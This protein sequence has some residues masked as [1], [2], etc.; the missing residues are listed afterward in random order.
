MAA[1]QFGGLFGLAGLDELDQ[2]AMIAQHL[3]APRRA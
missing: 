2:F 3:G 1:D